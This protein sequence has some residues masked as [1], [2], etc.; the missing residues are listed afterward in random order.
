M[1][2]AVDR[3]FERRLSSLINS[4]E[5]GILQG[6]LKGVEKESL[7]VDPDGR[8][9]HTPHPRALG[10]ALTNEHIT[11]DFSESLIELVTPAARAP[12][13]SCCS[14][15]ATC[16]G[17][18]TATS[19]TSC[20]GRPRCRATSASDADVPVARYGTSNTARMKTAYRNGLRNRY[21][22]RMQAISGVH[23]NYSFPAKLWD[24]WAAAREWRGPVDAAA[25]STGYFDLLRNYRRHGWLVLYLFGASPA[26][27]RSLPRRLACRSAAARC[28]RPPT[29]RTRPRC[30]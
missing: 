7:R 9:V 20:C 11:T 14:T 5:P 21:G 12:A 10:S 4:G 28:G 2:P 13:G 17:S 22:G 18:F 3:A 27:G 16:T 6:G 19:A 30:A 29:S 15:C 24:A 26:V 1:R 23:F 25:M 8:I